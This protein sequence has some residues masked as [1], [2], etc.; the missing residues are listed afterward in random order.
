MTESVCHRTG[1]ELLPAVGSGSTFAG[2][3]HSW[4]VTGASLW[5]CSASSA[6]WH[7]MQSPAVASALWKAA[8]VLVTIGG[9]TV[10]VWQAVQG[11]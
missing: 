9:E 4:Q 10:S 3:W 1:P 11:R 2:L 7:E 6:L 8:R 5:L